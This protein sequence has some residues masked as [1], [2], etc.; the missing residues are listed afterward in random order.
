MYIHIICIVI[1]RIRRRIINYRGIVRV[2]C[3][4]HKLFVSGVDN[5]TAANVLIRHLTHLK[6]ILDYVTVRVL[7]IMNLWAFDSF[8]V[9]FGHWH[10]R[11]LVL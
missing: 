10:Y 1:Y 6:V 4:V 2:N 7:L 9:V 11:I 5:F 3:L 8:A